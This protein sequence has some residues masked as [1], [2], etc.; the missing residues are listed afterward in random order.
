MSEKGLFS[1]LVDAFQES[2]ESWNLTD[3]AVAAR[4]AQASHEG[5]VTANKETSLAGLAHDLTDIVRTGV[6]IPRSEEEEIKERAYHRERDLNFWRSV[7]PDPK[8]IVKTVKEAFEPSRS[9][10]GFYVDSD[11]SGYE[12]TYTSSAPTPPGTSKPI[13][14]SPPHEDEE[15]EQSS[16]K[17]LVVFGAKAL[18]VTGL[19]L[20]ATAAFTAILDEAD[21]SRGPVVGSDKP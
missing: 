1:K 16:L 7:T 3:E 12:S 5:Q 17:K 15:I 8:H 21:K 14:T 18:A 6:P 19:V 2:A 11:S 10:D 9:P 4:H 13:V 20:L